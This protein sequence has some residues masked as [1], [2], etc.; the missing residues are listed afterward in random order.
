MCQLLS[1][2][3]MPFLKICF[4]LSLVLLGGCASPDNYVLVGNTHKPIEPAQVKYYPYNKPPAKYEEVAHFR[5]GGT[6]Y[7][8]EMSPNPFGTNAA[9]MTMTRADLTKQ[10]AKLGANGILVIYNPDDYLAG[11]I[12][13]GVWHPLPSG[14]PRTTNTVFRVRDSE[15]MAIYVTQE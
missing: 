1:K 4:A 8:K 12:S 3:K 14:T 15:A 6:S 7:M 5:S 10:A 9:V 11:S 2:M 13:N